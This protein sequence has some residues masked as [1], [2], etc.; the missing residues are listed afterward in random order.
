MRIN[1]NRPE[2]WK[3][4]IAE[5]VNYYNNWFI[6]CAP[7]IYKENKTRAS[8]SVRVTFEHTD[9]LRN[10]SPDILRN[11]PSLISVLRVSTCPPLAR[12]RLIG[13][14]QV[15]RNMV[16]SMESEDNPSI[17]TKMDESEIRQNL[18]RICN[19]IL[20]LID[21]DVFPWI[22]TSRD[23]TDDEK[24]RAFSII[25]DRL[26]G[27]LSN[28]IIR[29]SQE[30]KQ[31]RS[32]AE[33]LKS[34]GYEYINSHEVN[35][36]NPVPGTFTFRHNIE[37]FMG[38]ISS[39]EKNVNV[40]VDVYIVKKDYKKGDAPILIEAKSAGDFVNVNKRRKEE[41]QKMSLINRLYG[42]KA[43]Y[44]LFLS[45]YFNI[46]Y[47]EYEAAEGIDWVWEHR[48]SDLEKIGI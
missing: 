41:A 30:Q 8:Q 9:A 11:Y 28:S 26:C 16:N 45:G 29:N 23:P 13:L 43:H 38:E 33:W 31:L 47:L 37:V 7:D 10:I 36:K 48:I 18:N 2:L 42:H 19:V 6:E 27:A 22:K 35:N 21:H 12:D 34:K 20:K 4:D 3:K 15:P 17:P 24:K 14:A 39:A 32:I 25:T 5:S 46:G 44:V 1:I 40:P